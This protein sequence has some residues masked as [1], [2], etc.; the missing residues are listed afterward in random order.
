[1]TTVSAG[2]ESF[3]DRTRV[4]QIL[5][6]RG[7]KVNAA[8]NSGKTAQM[9]AVTDGKLKFARMLLEHGAEPHMTDAQGRTAFALAEEEN[10]KDYMALLRE[11]EGF[12]EEMKTCTVRV[13]PFEET[14]E[15]SVVA[16]WNMVLP[17]SAPH[18]D[19]VKVIRNKRAVEEDLFFVAERDGDVV[20]TVLGGYDGHRGWIYAVAVHPD[21]QRKGIGTALLRCMEE[22]LT[23]RG[24]L[25][26]NL[27][28]RASNAAVIAFYAA[29]GYEVEERISMGK[30]LYTSE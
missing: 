15:P 20:G 12:R 9:W 5:L 27:Q 4:L 23:K 13:R 17:D 10:L 24:C 22:A 8:D 1:M 11:Y 28:I 14:D 18:N 7:A 6:E 3:L 2:E 26:V 29:L 16:L 19:P 30:R 25:K 21:H